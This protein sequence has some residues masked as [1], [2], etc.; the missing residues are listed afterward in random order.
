MSQYFFSY[1]SFNEGCVHY[2][3]I[4]Q[5]IVSKKKAFLRAQV[6]RLNCGYPII[7]L[8]VRETLVSGSI[9]ELDVNDSYWSILDALLG[10]DMSRPDKSLFHRVTE[11]VLVENY[12]KVPCQIYCLGSNKTSHDFKRI[13]NGDWQKDM[14]IIPPLS[15]TLSDRHRKY[16]SRLS[17]TKG[18]DIVPIPMDLYRELISMEL[19]VDKGRR[20]ALTKLGKEVSLFLQ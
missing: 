6:F 20:V 14:G 5:F 3:K 12:S 1:G 13:P 19:I 10:L 15:A 11:D 4:S 8:S 7:D 2:P 17:K 18:R 16:I 9:L